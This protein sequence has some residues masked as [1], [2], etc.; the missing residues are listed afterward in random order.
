M[1]GTYWAKRFE[2][3]EKAQRAGDL[4]TAEKSVRLYVYAEKEIREKIS[5]QLN[6]FALNNNIS[7]SEAK[8]IL[9]KDELKEFRWTVDEYIKN[10]GENIFT[11][12]LTNA[13]AKVHI[14]R[15][16]AL[17]LEIKGNYWQTR[18]TPKRAFNRRF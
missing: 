5:Y 18:K 1:N 10:G 13:S 4:E 9:S 15:Y 17:L 6:R 16:E 2:E 11:K 7:L 3:I 8:R 12:E 14:R